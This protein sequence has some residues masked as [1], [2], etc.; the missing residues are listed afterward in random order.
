MGKKCA[1]S[2]FNIFR[3]SLSKNT[4]TINEIMVQNLPDM[5]LHEV[6][7]DA[8]GS[9][10]E[11]VPLDFRTAIVKEGNSEKLVIQA[12]PIK[13]NTIEEEMDSITRG[14][15]KEQLESKMDPDTA[16]GSV[17]DYLA[18]LRKDAFNVEEEDVV[19]IDPG[20]NSK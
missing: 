5:N 3:D 6:D 17:E 19:L 4:Q 16:I 2:T 7:S 13:Y 20:A 15:M 14:K 10:A 1:P 18:A 8:S 12:K 11:I 9:D